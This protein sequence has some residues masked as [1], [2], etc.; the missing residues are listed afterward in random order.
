MERTYTGDGPVH[1][2]EL[3]AWLL[4]S[5][6]GSHL[7]LASDPDGEALWP[8]CAERADRLAAHSCPPSASTRRSRRMETDRLHLRPWT[9]EPVDLAWAHRIYGDPE[10][11]KTIGGIVMKDLPATRAHMEMRLE[12]RRHWDQRFGAWAAERRHDGVVVG[13]A[14]M[15]PLPGPDDVKTYTEDIEIGWHLARAEW[16]QGYATELGAALVA[17]AR[18]RQIPRLHA[19]VGPTNARSVGVAERLGFEAR[20]MTRAYYGGLNLLHFV[21]EFRS[22]AR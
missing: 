8:T 18:Q 22:T 3:D 14:L 21:L 13:T 4:L 5:E 1:S 15:K 12:R 9:L 19:V 7:R 6:E 17:E 2:A 20:G 11:V 16:G 10:V